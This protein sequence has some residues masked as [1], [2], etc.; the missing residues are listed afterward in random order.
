MSSSFNKE[1]I[2]IQV[3]I[4]NEKSL[5]L[6]LDKGIELIKVIESLGLKLEGYVIA[7]DSKLINLNQVKNYKLDRDCKIS[8]LQAIEGG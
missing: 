8:I 4:L 2:N 1:K 7:L 5:S 3:D 6:E